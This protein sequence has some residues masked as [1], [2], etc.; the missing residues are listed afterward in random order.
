MKLKKT[1]SYLRADW[2][3]AGPYSLQEE[4]ASSLQ[5]LP[6]GADTC[7]P[8]GVGTA[9]IYDRRSTPG[10]ILA[11]IVKWTEGQQAS[12]VPHAASS[13]TVLL[14]SQSPPE[15]SDYWTGGGTLMV[16]EN[17]C[18]IMPTRLSARSIESYLRDLLQLGRGEEFRDLDRFQLVPI[19]NPETA[20]RIRD[21]GVTAFDLHFGKYGEQADNTPARPTMLQKLEHTVIDTLFRQDLRGQERPTITHGLNV[22]LMIS[23]IGERSGACSRKNSFR[24]PSALSLTMTRKALTLLRRKALLGG[25]NWCSGRLWRSHG[26]ATRTWQTI[27][28]LGSTCV[29]TCAN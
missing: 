6:N 10:G 4:L 22:K 14:A 12:T 7:L 17:H 11:H 29:S 21:E 25:V 28:T 8:L 15:N 16:F 9:A 20:K 24:L 27:E 2:G 23:S 18:L 13:P 19:S 1:I 26:F 5:R 3:S